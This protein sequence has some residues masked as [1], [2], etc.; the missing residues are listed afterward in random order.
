MT[1]KIWRRG[2]GQRWRGRGTRETTDASCTG[3]S[4]IIYFRFLFSPSQGECMRG[5]DLGAAFHCSWAY[6]LSLMHPLLILYCLLIDFCFYSALTPAE[7]NVHHEPHPAATI[8]NSN[9]SGSTNIQPKRLPPPPLSRLSNPATITLTRI[10]LPL[11][12]RQ[13]RY[14]TTIINI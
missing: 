14:W 13:R 1:K 11:S 2:K 5:S 3:K 9:D 12:P 8:S 4:F 10:P 6:F 7:C